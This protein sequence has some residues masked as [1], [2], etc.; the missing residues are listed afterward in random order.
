MSIQTITNAQASS[1]YA[2]HETPKTEQENAAG[3]P[4]EREKEAAVYEKSKTAAQPKTTYTINRMR[5][6]DRAALVKQ[7]KSEQ[8]SRYQSLKNLVET[9]M[10]KQAKTFSMA[11]DD[12]IWQFLAGGD[13]TVTEA[14]KV[15]AQKDISED[16][17]WGVKQTS[18]RLFDFASALAGDDPDKMKQ[19]QEAMQKGYGQAEKAWGREL[20]EISSQTLEAANR[21]FEA[22][23]ADRTTVSTTES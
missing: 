3:K 17:Y 21:L 9:M 6:E 11:Q 8:E 18:Q 15:Q 12:A 1:V 4:Q 22:Y 23:Y 19:M 7:L 14:A 20:P 16:G 10:G 2:T 13:Y 5:E